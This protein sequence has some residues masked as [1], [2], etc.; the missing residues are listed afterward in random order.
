MRSSLK[1]VF[2][3]V[4]FFGTLA[5][6]TPAHA[7][8][9]NYFCNYSNT[10][11]FGEQFDFDYEVGRNTIF[12]QQHENGNY[13]VNFTLGEVVKEGGILRFHF[14]YW[15]EGYV[16][17]YESHSLEFET[18]QLS[19]Q[20]IFYAE[21]EKHIN[22]GPVVTAE[23]KSSQEKSVPQ[24]VVENNATKE[25][26]DTAQSQT[27]N[28]EISCHTQ[29]YNNNRVKS[30]T[31]CVSSQLP[32]QKEYAYGPDQLILEGA[33]CE[34]EEGQGIGVGIEMSFEAK[35]NA[36]GPPEFDK[37]LIANGYGKST[38]TFMENSRVKQVEIKTDTG[39][40]WVRTLKD[41]T[42]IQHVSLG[43]SIRPN[44]IVVT[45]LDVYPGQKY[46]DTCLSF[47]A[48]ELKN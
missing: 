2:L 33:W 26:K 43:E 12:I 44:G 48:P 45:I 47:L 15:Y 13:K 32:T 16:A 4:S 36:G 9:E 14:E 1:S 3:I 37:L 17:I 39:K 7:S 10:S 41:E 22:T 29:T 20:R 25:G 46:E 24:V 19:S 27:A 23:C 18:M 28:S 8:V 35:S 21:N 34:G 42:G 11:I 6:L 40:F 38:K 5:W 31:W 30:G